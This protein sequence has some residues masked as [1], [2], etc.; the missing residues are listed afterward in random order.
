[1]APHPGDEWERRCPRSYDKPVLPLSGRRSI[2]AAWPP[3]AVCE[4]CQDGPV[5]GGGYVGPVSGD[6]VFYPA[7]ET[8][9]VCESCARKMLELR[10]EE[11]YGHG[12]HRLCTDRLHVQ[13]I[14]EQRGVVEQ[15]AEEQRIDHF[16]G[17]FDDKHGWKVVRVTDALP[18]APRGHYRRLLDRLDHTATRASLA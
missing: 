14:A 9:F 6:T 2:H 16:Q 10:P 12:C 1:M 4:I 11:L 5:N 3:G 13:Q 7:P 8:R 17:H 15:M 18:D